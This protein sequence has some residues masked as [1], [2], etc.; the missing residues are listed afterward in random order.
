MGRRFLLGTMYLSG[1]TWLTYVL[2]FVITIAVA[3]LLGP[4]DLGMYAFV[5]AVNE[6]LN[7]VSAFSLGHALL[8]AREESDRLSET[9]YGLCA[10]LGVV[11]LAAALLVAPALA[12][13]RSAEAAWFIVVLAVTRIPWIMAGV[14]AA[15]M[16]RSLQYGRFAV[17]SLVTGNVPNLCALGLALAGA[18]PWSLLARDVL[19][20]LLTY[21]LTRHWSPKRLRMRIRREEARQLLRFARPMFV[22][23]SLDMV[24][25]RI[26]RLGVGFLFGDTTL[27]LYHQA[28]YVSEIG[29]LAVRPVQQLC[30]NLY[31]RLQDQPAPLARACGIVNYFLVRASYAA[32]VLFIAFPAEVIRVL[33]GDAWIGASGFL[34]ALGFYAALLPLLDNLQWLLYASG[35][36]QENIRLRLVQLPV[37]LLVF[38]ASAL[39]RE[40]VLMA[41]ALVLSTAAGTLMAGWY[42]REVLRGTLARIL[43]VPSLVLVVTLALCFALRAWGLLEPVPAILVPAL[44][45]ALFALLLLLLERSELLSQLGYLR[46]QLE[47]RPADAGSANAAAG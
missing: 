30:Y 44:P 34:R 17:L 16:E 11:S 46:R 35:R 29:T 36:M 6:L 37:L 23:R 10:V 14:P 42:A 47:A 24:N 22:S 4:A 1:G 2:N 27:G 32:A 20:A 21:A 7:L 38:A 43:G 31:C 12:H 5:A 40:P 18:G 26:D 33:L 25:Q 41:L 39:V 9:A 28:R 45:P 15:L 3:R 8:Q 13:Y 19:L